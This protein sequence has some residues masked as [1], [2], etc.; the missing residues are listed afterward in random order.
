[1]RAESAVA[2]TFSGPE[3]AILPVVETLV[4]VPQST[5]IVV[6]TGA[7]D[8]DTAYTALVSQVSDAAGNVS[9]QATVGFTSPGAF[10]PFTPL[11]DDIAPTVA[12][13]RATSPTEV[14][15]RFSERV[16]SATVVAEAFALAHAEGGVAPT[17]VSVRPAQG[18]L[19]A[20]ITTS[21]QERQE[22]YTLSLTGIEDVAGN[23]MDDLTLPFDGF[24]EF[25][26]PEIEWAQPLSPTRVAVKWNEAVTADS[27]TRPEAYVINGLTI[28]SVRFSNSDALKNAA[29]NPAWAPLRQDIVILSTSPMV[30]AGAYEV[31][32]TGVQDLS[33]NDSSTSATFDGVGESP[34]VDVILS[35]LVSDSATVVGVGAGGAPGT[36]GRALSPSD[37]A[38]QREG[39][40]VVGTALNESGST[41]VEDHAFTIALGGFPPDGAPLDGVEFE[42][43]DDGTGGDAAANDNVY[44]A[45]ISSVPLG[46]TISFKAFASFTSS[47]GAENPQFPGAAFADAEAGPSVFGDGQEYP[48]NDNAVFLVADRDE[49]GIIRV[50]NLF[51]DEISFKRKTGFPAFHFAIDHARRRD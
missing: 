1:M 38:T 8:L 43:V 2:I 19:S 28:S 9:G 18:G 5:Q 21:E 12:S 36:P 33:L 7:M 3:G 49:D 23:E 24:G 27:A 22:A 16:A 26:A 30:P 41:P 14:E 11:V 25:D 15:V 13:V 20:I 40:F 4:G 17:L 35:Y 50:D 31:V 45:R 29:F 34:E 46:S 32:A 47:F 10:S 37:V 39:I 6:R 51:G 42:L 44:T 48:G